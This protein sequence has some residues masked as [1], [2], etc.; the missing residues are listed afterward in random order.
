MKN[1]VFIAII[2]L[3]CAFFYSCENTLTSV[4]DI[5][6][7]EKDVSYA[8]Q[9]EPFLRYTCSYSGCHGASA[10]GGIVLDNYTSI[11]K[12]PGLVTPQYPD[13]SQLIQ[14]LENKLPHFTY[15]ERMQIT[16]NHIEGMRT[17]VREGCFNN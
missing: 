11:I 6:F 13:N 17:W 2:L 7:P 5:V 15:F 8:L 10:A 3:S 9:V 16:P 4:K 1:F 12:V 14:I